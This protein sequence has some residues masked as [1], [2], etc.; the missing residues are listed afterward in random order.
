VRWFTEHFADVWSHPT[1]LDQQVQK[2]IEGLVQQGRAGKGEAATMIMQL[3]SLLL[4]AI[5]KLP[6]APHLKL[7]GRQQG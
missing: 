5:A 2:P 1:T 3:K 7:S 4:H 6:Y